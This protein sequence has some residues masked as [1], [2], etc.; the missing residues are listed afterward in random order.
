[1]V[2]VDSCPSSGWEEPDK[3]FLCFFVWRGGLQ[4]RRPG[5]PSFS[6]RLLGLGCGCKAWVGM[7]RFVV[8]CLYAALMPPRTVKP[9][10][11]W[12]GLGKLL[13]VPA[14]FLGGYTPLVKR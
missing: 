2:M 3:T 11:G 10:L 1:M 5:S 7:T 8:H 6:A 13:R 9:M 4:T 12:F 14:L